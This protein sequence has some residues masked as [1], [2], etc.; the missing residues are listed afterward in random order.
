[1]RIPRVKASAPRS[2]A[3]SGPWERSVYKFRALALARTPQA[4]QSTRAPIGQRFVGGEG[5]QANSRTSVTRSTLYGSSFRAPLRWEE[6]SQSRRSPNNHEIKVS[7]LTGVPAGRVQQHPAAEFQKSDVAVS[8]YTNPGAGCDRYRSFPGK[9]RQQCA[10]QRCI[11]CRVVGQYHHRRQRLDRPDIRFGQVL[12][13]F[14]DRARP[15][16]HNRRCDSG[17]TGCLLLAQRRRPECVASPVLRICDSSRAGYQL[18]ARC[19]RLRFSPYV[20][21]A[22][23]ER[24]CSHHIPLFHRAPEHHPCCSGIDHSQ[25]SDS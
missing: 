21:V 8:S 7:S 4:A 17:K 3:A 25:C 12:A 5:I 16:G 23:G 15:L 13:F 20:T 14:H 9:A 19:T 2:V 22:G 18:F 24:Q 11:W 10:I 6:V 1:M